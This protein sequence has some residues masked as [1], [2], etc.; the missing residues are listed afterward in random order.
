MNPTN[1]TIQLEEYPSDG[2][3][4]G[5]ICIIENE[6]VTYLQMWFSNDTD[7][8]CFTSI[9]NADVFEADDIYITNDML[10]V[11]STDS[12]WMSDA[13]V[14]CFPRLMPDAV[15]I[16]TTVFP[17]GSYGMGDKAVNINDSIDDSELF[18]V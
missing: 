14:D 11:I 13:F 8:A 7:L 15:T 9:V 6:N 3:G 5:T 18:S 10:N 12:N 1:T 4:R 16:T 17:Y 2:L